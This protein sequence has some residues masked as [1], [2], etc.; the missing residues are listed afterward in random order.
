MW[1]LCLLCAYYVMMEVPSGYVETSMENGVVRVGDQE[2]TIR[3]GHKFVC[4]RRY[5]KYIVLQFKHA[6]SF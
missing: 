5:E 3:E 6:F 1:W 2:H 4:A